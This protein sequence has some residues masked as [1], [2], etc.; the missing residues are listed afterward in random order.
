ML[1]F[2]FFKILTKLKV[3]LSSEIHCYGVLRVVANRRS[4]IDSVNRLIIRIKPR[5]DSKG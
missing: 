4:W 1:F 2:S 3:D 5:L